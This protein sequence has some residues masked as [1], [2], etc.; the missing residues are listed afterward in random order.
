MTFIPH[1]YRGAAGTA[2]QRQS[3]ALR[4]VRRTYATTYDHFMDSGLYK[5]LVSDRLMLRLKESGLKY[6]ITDDAYRVVMLQ[7]IP[8]I[9][10]PHEW[11]FS[12]WCEAAL[13][14]L[15]VAQ[16]ALRYDM[17]LADVSPLTVQFIDGK[18][19]FTEPFA[20]AMREREWSA[21]SQFV[22]VWL[23]PLALMAQVDIAL[24]DLLQSQ[25]DGIPQTWAS[26]M[27]PVRT[28]FNFALS[29]H[30]SGDDRKRAVL[31]D[32]LDNLYAAIAHLKWEPTAPAISVQAL[33]NPFASATVDHQ[34]LLIREYLDAAK[35][36]VIWDMYAADDTLS[37]IGRE[38]KAQ[39]LALHPQRA[40]IEHLHTLTADDPNIVPLVHDWLNPTS[41]GGW[42]HRARQTLAAR[43]NPDLLMGVG[44]IPKL[45][46]GG[47]LPFGAIAAYLAQ[48]A[49]YLLV[50]YV[51]P[52]DPEAVTQIPAGAQVRYTE[53]DFKSAFS[54]YYT[55]EHTER[56]K[57]TER[58]MFL[59]KR[60]G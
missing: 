2:F 3:R 56:V 16:I 52:N 34:H 9:T 7:P 40:V 32:V 51:P 21:Y 35:P 26:A 22:R 41:A 20:F 57:H 53:A 1:E 54:E 27:L 19:I 49:P 36:D 10:Y 15:H 55:V 18:P 28:R 17:M 6:A 42:A 43:S 59:F 11:G 50:D 23:A 4:E 5:A 38:K 29:S 8:L 60:K 14:V 24:G 25:P 58:V 12:Q 31:P 47:H 46:I 45:N 37:R 13:H 39:V 33:P 30:F 44:V 48:I